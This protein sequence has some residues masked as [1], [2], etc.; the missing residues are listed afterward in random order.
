M[1]KLRRAVHSVLLSLIVLSVVSISAEA[2]AV[3]AEAPLSKSKLIVAWSQPTMTSGIPVWIAEEKGL[4]KKYG[5][6]VELKQISSAN[7]GVPALLAGEIEVA[8]GFGGPGAIMAALQGAELAIIASEAPNSSAAIL[9]N[10]SIAGPKDLRG[11]RVAITRRASTSWFAIRTALRKWEMDPDRD[12]FLL[13][14]GG[15]GEIV[16]ALKSGAAQAGVFFDHAVPMI[17]EM[18]YRE[19]ASLKGFASLQ[20]ADVVTKKF[21]AEHPDTLRAFLKAYLE[22]LRVFHTDKNES[23]RIA[24]KY[25][26]LKEG[27]KYL[28]NDYD[29]IVAGEGLLPKKPY[30]TEE[31]IATV[32]AELPIDQK[33]KAKP[34][35]FI[36]VR[37]LRELDRSGFIDGLYGSQK[38]R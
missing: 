1:A 26:R 4:F 9:A 8:A 24:Q 29:A 10:P 20:A 6:E 14:A 11:T 15:L 38:N 30:P 22:A 34:V 12:V 37:I 25:I 5:L 28:E 18:G 21:L 13:E 19:L 16:A 32:L 17:K 31:S 36:D 27:T 3:S 7:L 23:V 33:G 35:E 2:T